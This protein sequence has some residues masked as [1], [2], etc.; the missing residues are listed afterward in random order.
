MFAGYFLHTH[1]IYEDKYRMFILTQ[2][3]INQ[4]Q[5]LWVLMDSQTLVKAYGWLAKR[6]RT[7][8]HAVNEPVIV[9]KPRSCIPLS[10]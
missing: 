6:A 7:T 4:R 3:N 2:H 8:C 1:N 5:R 10:Y 9:S